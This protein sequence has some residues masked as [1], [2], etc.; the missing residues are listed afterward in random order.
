VDLNADVG[1]G[2]PRAD[3]E[4][5]R[6]V[7][8]ANIACGMH[9]GDPTTMR[10]T[11]ELAVE[12]D[13]AIGAHPSLADREGFGRRVI[14]TSASEVYDLVLYQI[15]ALGAIARAEGTSMTHVKPHGALYTMA[16]RDPEL[17]DAIA[18]AVCDLDDTLVLVGLAGSEL[19]RAAEAH[20]LP[21]A[22]EVF[23]DRRY[24][25]DGYLLARD[26]PRALVVDARHAARRVLAMLDGHLPDDEAPSIAVVAD[27]VCVHGDTP[28]A[29][30]L[31]RE[32]RDQLERAGVTIMRAAAPAL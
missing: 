14:A 4:L 28:G 12:C 19:V 10:R 2:D 25:R 29:A 30:M 6:I 32:L 26:D 8:S 7:T 17:A 5:L 20:G 27:T 13:V 21:V 18:S 1:E 3:A 23:A 24:A 9:A 16:A 31:A 22:N 15:G 11:V